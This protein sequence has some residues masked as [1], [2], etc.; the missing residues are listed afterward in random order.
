V[1]RLQLGYGTDEDS[2]QCMGYSCDAEPLKAPRE[3]RHSKPT[4]AVSATAAC[5][6][7]AWAGGRMVAIDAERF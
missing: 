5:R 7:A 2:T 4:L 6:C 1:N 3:A